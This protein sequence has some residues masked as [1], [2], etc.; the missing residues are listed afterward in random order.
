MKITDEGRVRVA[1]PEF[2]EEIRRAYKRAARLG[3]PDAATDAALRARTSLVLASME[4]EVPTPDE[5]GKFL[6]ENIVEITALLHEI[7]GVVH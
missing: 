2:A 5:F 7:T 6:E 1:S 4:D 3:I